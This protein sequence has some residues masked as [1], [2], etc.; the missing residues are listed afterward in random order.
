[1]I[2][3]FRMAQK[4]WAADAFTGE[5]AKKGRRWNHKDIP[6]TYVAEYLSLAALEI[7]VHFPRTA[8]GVPFVFFKIEIPD[9]IEISTIEHLP[10]D[11]Q[12]IPVPLSTRDIGTQWFSEGKTAVLEVPSAIIPIEKNYVLNPLHPDFKKIVIGPATDFQ[13]DIR[14]L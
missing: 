4:K 14:I 7:I 11:W 12:D 5:G 9:G 3:A 10:K 1:M 8:L 6:V 13:F 2:T